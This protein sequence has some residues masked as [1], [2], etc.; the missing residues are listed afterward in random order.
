MHMF[1]CSMEDRFSFSLRRH[2]HYFHVIEKKENPLYFYPVC[3]FPLQSSSQAS[4]PEHTRVGFLLCQQL[5]FPPNTEIKSKW[6]RKQK[7]NHK[8]P[9]E[10]HLNVRCEL[11]SVSA[12]STQSGYEIFGLNRF[13]HQAGRLIAS[14]HRESYKTVLLLLKNPDALT[15]VLKVFIFRQL[16]FIPLSAVGCFVHDKL[17]LIGALICILTELT[18][19]VSEH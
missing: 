9:L 11:Q 17:I 18:H 1:S 13:S 2:Q 10:M 15:H 16:L 19:I 7:S 14:S 6:A 12:G 3:K 4:W 8:W 5:H